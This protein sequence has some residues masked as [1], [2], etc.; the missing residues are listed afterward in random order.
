MR[1]KIIAIILFIILSVLPGSKA[2]FFNGLPLSAPEIIFSFFALLVISTTSWE[3]IKMLRTAV[4]LSLSLLLLL[5]VLSYKFLSYGWSVCVYSEIS[6]SALGSQCE[7]SFDDKSGNTSYI[8]PAIDF[9]F[10]NMP[11]YFLNNS[12]SF[13][14]FRSG[15]P[16]RK[17]LPFTLESSAYIYPRE[18]DYLL[19]RSEKD[20]KIEINEKKYVYTASSK[21]ALFPLEEGKINY[22]KSIYSSTR[23]KSN[24]LSLRS[25]NQPFYSNQHSFSDKWILVYRSANYFLLLVLAICLTY[26]FV[27]NFFNL[28]KGDQLVWGTLFLSLVVLSIVAKYQIEE[29]K[30]LLFYSHLITISI[31]ILF[32]MA[33]ESMEKKLIFFI[34]LLLFFIP[35]IWISYGINPE[36]V[37]ILSGGKDELSH[38]TFARQ[39]IPVNDFESFMYAPG[40]ELFYYQPLHRYLLFMLHKFFGEPMWGPYVMQAFLFNLAAFLNIYALKRSVGLG[41]ALSFAIL[42][43]ILY[44]SFPTP[45]AAFIKSPL[46]QALALP[47]LMIGAAIVIFL[48]RYR[49]R[50]IAKYF[51]TG[52]ILGA[53]FMIRTDWVL[54]LSILL[55]LVIWQ[56]WTNGI[57]RYRIKKISILL[58]GFIIFPVLI[59]FRNY[60]VTEK[61]AILPTSGQVNLLEDISEAIRG[62]VDFYEASNAKIIVEIVKAFWGRYDQLAHILWDNIGGNIIGKKILRQLL[63]YTM[64]VLALFGFFTL[65]K[66]KDY[67]NLLVAVS[68]FLSL[69]FLVLSGSIFKQHNNMAMSAIYDYFLILILA[70]NVQA[71]LKLCPK[72]YRNFHFWTSQ[73]TARYKTI[74]SIYYENIG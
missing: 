40:K 8:Y 38:E 11:L 30:S 59:G 48:I 14:F 56:L 55:L 65:F 69:L 5:Q 10:K 66:R 28:N 60:Y 32:I 23:N 64:S 49:E 68:F 62:K 24:F 33:R 21:E 17:T 44:I 43:F 63:W 53:S 46:Q 36:E 37:I 74:K 18:K 1:L 52:L 22:I 50:K 72:K 3:K 4:F 67:S 54:P 41:A 26:G 16:S 15:E 20:V 71:L 29:F 39:L 70:L 7:P 12:T 58:L 27:F 13:G 47:L 35:C 42:Y 51:F 6:Q 45:L 25:G 73:L 34:L 57:S 19:V 31:F 61:I 9:S 2:G